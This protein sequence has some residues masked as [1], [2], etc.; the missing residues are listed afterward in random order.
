MKDFLALILTKLG[1]G[2]GACVS[3]ATGI[4]CSMCDYFGNGLNAEAVNDSVVK[5]SYN[6]IVFYIVY[7]IAPATSVNIIHE[8]SD[9]DKKDLPNVVTDLVI[10]ETYDE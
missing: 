6:N 10:T 3:N 4:A 2:K 8:P 5:V 1:L 7:T 9:N